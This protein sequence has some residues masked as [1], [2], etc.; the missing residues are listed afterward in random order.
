MIYFCCK[1]I[2]ITH[3]MLLR[4][5]TSVGHRLLIV[6]ADLNEM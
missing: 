3:Q 6:A 2:P 1:N 4:C 5:L